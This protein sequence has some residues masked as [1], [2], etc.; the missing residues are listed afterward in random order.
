MKLDIPQVVELLELAFGEKME[1]GGNT[2]RLSSPND[3]PHL[4]WW[5]YPQYHRLSPGYV[6]QE[7]G[8]IIGNVTL[9]NTKIP[10]RH[11]IANV[12]VHPD[13]RRR[14]IARQLMDAVMQQVYARQ[15][16]VVTLQVVKDNVAAVHLY[17]SLQFVT[18][19]HMTQW[20]VPV[21]RLRELTPSVPRLPGGHLMEPRP[22]TRQQGAEAYQLDVACLSPDLNWPEPIT[23]DFY[24][25]TLWRTIWDFL[26]GRQL[27]AW[28]I[29]D[30]QEHLVGLAVIVSEWERS[31]ELI[32]RI[33]PRWRGR[34]ERPLLS[35]LIRRLRQMSRRTVQICYPDDDSDMAMLLQEANFSPR[36]VLSHM[37]LDVS[38][39]MR[40]V[41]HG[42]R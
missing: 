31:Y 26:N 4:T 9:I 18:V 35:K 30:E 34:L 33:H 11:I 3:Q 41:S 29:T 40:R 8:R 24:K 7:D 25:R 20:Q 32:L 36:R 1:S 16:E 38:P 23:P 39:Q 5:L 37:R 6:W 42:I 22:L 2:V 10:G 19:G 28:G 21:S 14:G 13:Y 12:A 15:G 17:E 27:E